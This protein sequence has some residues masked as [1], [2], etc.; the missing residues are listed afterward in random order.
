MSRYFV[1]YDLNKPGQDYPDLIRKLKSYSG[2]WHCLDSTWLIQTDKSCT[3]IRDELL[4][5]MDSSS[6]LLV[7]ELG[8]SARAWSG[9]E[10][11]CS[12]WL[13]GW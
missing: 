8:D 3:A 10:K 9:F 6:K 13:R 12:D 4:A 2:W 5:L 1:G 7:I 11:Q